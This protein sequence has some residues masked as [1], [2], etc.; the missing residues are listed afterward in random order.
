[1]NA[2][3]KETALLDP[4]RA[5]GAWMDA[6]LDDRAPSAPLAAEGGSGAVP[7]TVEEGSSAGQSLHEPGISS[8]ARFRAQ[9]FQVAGLTLAIP[10][11]QVDAVVDATAVTPRSESSPPLWGVLEDGAGSC[12]VVDTAQ[13][14]LPAARSAALGDP[15]ARCTAVLRLRGG[16]ALACERVGE[17]VEIEAG[18]V[19]WR[20]ERAQRTWLAGTLRARSM[21]LLDVEAL[22]RQLPGMAA[23][24]PGSAR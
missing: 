20:S 9:S 23:Q 4:Q 12:R 13:V 8:R 16:W 22:G 15:A 19:C 7:S 5:L 21:A 11:D 18:E 24:G 17:V 2:W 1:M 10:L 3:D 14:V 6:L